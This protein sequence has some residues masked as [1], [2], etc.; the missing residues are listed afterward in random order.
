MGRRHA[1]NNTA[2]SFFTSWEKKEA[3]Y[4]TKTQRIGTEYKLPFGHCRLGL[5]IAV[6]PVV[7]PS[8]NIYS[9]EAIYQ[10]LLDHQKELDRARKQ[11]EKE[12]AE[13]TKEEEAKQEAEEQRKLI[14]FVKDSE[15]VSRKRKHEDDT[16]KKMKEFLYQPHKAGDIVADPRS[17]A[18]KLGELKRTSFWLPRFGPDGQKTKTPKP[19]KRPQSPFSR[20][21]LRLKDLTPI[22]LPKLPAEK[23]QPTKFCC[24]VSQKQITYQ[25]TVF[26][27]NTGIVM[28][29]KCFKE[30]AEPTM[31]CPVTGKKFKKKH[32]I[33]IKSD[34]TGFAATG[35]V[36]AKKWDE[37]LM[38]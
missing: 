13:A 12:Q 10:Y 3:G 32:V 21:P 36:I 26:L 28:L 7:T 29:A 24:A 15:R 2:R 18:Q 5:Q 8:G 4:G 22:K 19:P 9:K 34:G 31:T 11:W 17:K 20:K 23:G 25:D 37:A 27:K 38:N 33:V 6:D 30:L 1:L 35:N 16:R 14:E